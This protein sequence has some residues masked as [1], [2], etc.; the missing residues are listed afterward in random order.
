MPLYNNTVAPIAAANKSRVNT[1]ETTTSAAYVGLTTAQT[2]TVNVPASGSVVIFLSSYA[3]NNT[4]GVSCY[5]S[6]AL[7]GANTLA[8]SDANG[9]EYI[10]SDANY[11]D[12]RSVATVLTGLTPGSTTFTMQFRTGTGTAT[13]RDRELVVIPF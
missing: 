7:S 11:R 8:A 9:T 12:R 6:V 4:A 13:F 2:V 10:T 5:A 3:S 1:S